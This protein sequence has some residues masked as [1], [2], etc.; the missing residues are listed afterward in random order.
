M[1]CGEGAR[2]D[3]SR[4]PV[5]ARGPFAALALNPRA[6]FVCAPP[7]WSDQYAGVVAILEIQGM[8]LMLA[9]V[10]VLGVKLFAL[11]TALMFPAPAYEAASKM[12]KPA[13]GAILG[14]GVVAQLVM[15][16]P[17]TLINLIFLVAALVYLADVRPALRNLLQR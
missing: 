8:V 12:T 7:L 17:I 16:T 11:V 5:C 4:Q 13:W 9:F 3:L 10:A 6:L 1:G 2:R 15:P 14:I